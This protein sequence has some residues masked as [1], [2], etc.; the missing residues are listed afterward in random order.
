MTNDAMDRFWEIFFE[1]YENIP[2]Q[3]PGNE[4]TALRA[5][6][7]CEGLPEEPT[8]VDAGCGSG[9]QSLILARHTK[10]FVTALDT[11]EP[12]I[13]ALTEAAAAAHLSERVCAIVADMA[14]PPIEAESV[15]LIWSEGAVYFIG[16]ARALELWRPLL[17]PGGYVAFT[18]AVWLREDPPE[19]ICES[20]Q[21]EYP[22]MGEIEA[23]LKIIADSGYELIGHFTIPDEAWYDDF[24]TPMSRQIGRLREVYEDDPEAL[25]VLE[26]IEAEIDLHGRFSDYYGYEFF[27]LR[28][29]A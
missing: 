20:W 26:T 17:R 5:L 22:T 10:G 4:A 7:M 24:Y 14:A 27:V 8:I 16:V 29:P 6:G 9:A 28:V 19:E 21:K 12:F 1:V 15:D 25:T 13:D 11:H 2:R 18:E 3:G 23:N